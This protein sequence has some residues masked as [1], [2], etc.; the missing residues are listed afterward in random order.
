LRTITPLDVGEDF[1]RY[2]DVRAQLSEKTRNELDKRLAGKTKELKTEL[3]ELRTKLEKK[4]KNN[5][6]D[7]YRFTPRYAPYPLS[8][9][10]PSPIYSPSPPSAQQGPLR[11]TPT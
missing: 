4:R 8:T 6:Q 11:Y 9:Q 7:C 3:N 10:Q 1:G 2:S 5:E